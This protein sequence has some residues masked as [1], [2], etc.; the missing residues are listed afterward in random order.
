MNQRVHHVVVDPSKHWVGRSPGKDDELDPQQGHQDQSGPHRLQVH[1]R[2]LLLGFLHFLHKH[3][4]DVEQ[5]EEVDLQRYDRSEQILQVSTPEGHHF[6]QFSFIQRGE[7]IAPTRD[8]SDCLRGNIIG[9]VLR[10]HGASVEP[11]T[12]TD[13][14]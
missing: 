8:T 7:Q 6:P 5:K 10:E 4:D 1:V 12:L 9:S 11:N 3:P 2:F 13:V 14:N